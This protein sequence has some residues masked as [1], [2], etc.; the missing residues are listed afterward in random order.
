MKK[1]FGVVIIGVLSFAMIAYAWQDDWIPPD[2]SPDGPI[3]SPYLSNAPIIVDRFPARGK[4]PVVK[5][6]TTISWRVLF[7]ESTHTSYEVTVRKE[8]TSYRELP[9]HL[10]VLYPGRYGDLDGHFEI[11]A[12]EKITRIKKRRYK[13]WMPRYHRA[14]LGKS[15]GSY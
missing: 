10:V 2:S 7:V 13:Y 5:Y 11:K 4:N 12:T 14:I 3:T 8:I 9:Y 15:K 6:K 1:V